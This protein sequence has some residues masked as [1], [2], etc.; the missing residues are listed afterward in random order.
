M[1]DNVQ[2]AI[3]KATDV[4]RSVGITD[5]VDAVRPV[6]G[7]DISS[8]FDVSTRGDANYIVKI[9]PEAF[10]WKLAKE[11]FIYRQMSAVEDLPTPKVIAWDDRRRIIDADFLV[12]SKLPGTMMSAAIDA[13]V[14]EQ[15]EVY[16]QLGTVARAVHRLTFDQFGYLYTGV[17]EGHAANREYMQFQFD[18]KLAE[19]RALGGAADVGTAIERPNDSTSTASTT[20]WNCGIG[21]PRP[22]TEVGPTACRRT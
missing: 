1:L 18:K 2:T 16:R 17:V 21:S 15:I 4:L 13:S 7:G 8:V 20:R 6:G 11:V 19:F 10:A 14:D 12:L 3:T 9:Y 22:A 5:V